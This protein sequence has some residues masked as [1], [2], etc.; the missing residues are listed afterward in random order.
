[1]H[2]YTHEF[3]ISNMTLMLK[4]CFLILLH[5]RRCLPYSTLSSLSS[6]PLP[7]DD[8]SLLFSLDYSHDTLSVGA[9]VAHSTLFIV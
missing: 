5:L 1:M 8:K 7:P 6:L 3:M 2:L 9:T 4:R